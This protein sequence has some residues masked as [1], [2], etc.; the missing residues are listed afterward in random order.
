MNLNEHPFQHIFGLSREWGGAV[1]EFSLYTYRPQSILD[2]RT[3][4]SVRV[5]DFNRFW[6]EKVIAQLRDGEELAFHSKVK[7]GN[8]NWHVPLID[9]SCSISDLDLAKNTLRKV[10]PNNMTSGLQYYDSGRSMHAYGSRLMQRSEWIKVMGALL[11]AN[12]PNEQA[13]VDS[14]WVG[15]RLMGGFTSLRWTSNSGAYLKVPSLLNR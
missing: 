11:L 14:R 6:L 9:F 10:L 8:R 12:F 7:R 15:H 2:E 4:I 5:E 13:I 3:I 1:L